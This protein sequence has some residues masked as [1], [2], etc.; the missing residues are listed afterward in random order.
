MQQCH[1][2]EGREGSR[3]QVA[4]DR[5]VDGEKGQADIRV[6]CVKKMQ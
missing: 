1:M 3:A 2:T 6:N 4:K 5:D